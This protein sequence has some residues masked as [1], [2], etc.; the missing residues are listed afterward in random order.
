MAMS[1]AEIGQRLKSAR[2][3]RGKTQAQIARAL[4]MTR[5]NVS[6]IEKGDNHADL[7]VLESYAKLVGCPMIFDLGAAD[8]AA[9]ALL[10]RLSRVVRNL[11]GA[12]LDTLAAMV[13]RWEGQHRAHR[14]AS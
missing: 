8:D 6:L 4:K 9:G 3:G 7:D 2:E 11:D 13:D 10:A 5:Q 1:Y 14:R 12:V